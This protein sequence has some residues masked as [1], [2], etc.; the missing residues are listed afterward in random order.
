VIQSGRDPLRSGKSGNKEEFTLLYQFVGR[1]LRRPP[2]ERREVR[3][4]GPGS[5]ATP[6]RTCMQDGQ[7]DDFRTVPVGFFNT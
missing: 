5:V 2:A 6:R 7:G 3:R 1:K 4:N